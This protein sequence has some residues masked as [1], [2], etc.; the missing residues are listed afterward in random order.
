MAKNI[1]TLKREILKTLGIN[2]AQAGEWRMRKISF[3]GVFKIKHDHD[4]MNLRH[5]NKVE[6]VHEAEVQEKKNCNVTVNRLGLEKHIR[7]RRTSRGKNLS[8]KI[9]IFRK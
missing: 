4:V 9:E 5:D 7:I 6:I 8:H 1:F 3:E 2:H